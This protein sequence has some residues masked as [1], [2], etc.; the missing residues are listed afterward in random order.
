V[1]SPRLSV[2][3]YTVREQAAD[4]LGATL[5]RIADIGY[6]LVEPYGFVNFGPAL[7][8]G[9]RASGLRAPTTHQG[10]IGQGEAELDEVFSKAAALGIETVIDPHVP[11]ERWQE[12]ADVRATAEALN[13]AAAVAARHGVRV[14]YHNHAHEIASKIE[15]ET[16][17]EF[18]AGLLDAAVV[19]EVDTYWVVVGGE[20]PVALLRRLG[21]RV[22]AVHVK[23]GSGTDDVTEQV[24]V[25]SG[26]LPVADIVA[27][28]PDALH[29]VELDDS[30]GDRFE[31]IAESYAFLTALAETASNGQAR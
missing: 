21:D 23:D 25:G 24:A 2:Q 19:L 16:A 15:G 3:L 11:T 18:F 27:A 31:A 6:E 30:K 17:L 5:Q 8:E 7:G 14:G 10:F 26:S 28:V 12:A 13:A 22:V 1:T 4:D 20:E 9:L 29:V